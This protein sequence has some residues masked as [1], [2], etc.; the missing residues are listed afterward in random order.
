GLFL[1][2]GG[3]VRTVVDD[4]GAFA[5]FGFAPALNARGQVA[6]EGTTK[7]G[8]VG[9]FTGSDPKKDRVIAVGDA[10]DGSIVVDLGASAFGAAL[11]NNGQIAF[12]AQLAD[13]RT[14]V[15]RADP[16]PAVDEDGHEEVSR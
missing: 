9:I 1:S 10:L 3:A 16:V 2:S 15:Y 14:G 7:A 8:R 6:F 11:N 5:S 4:T 12:I 13:G